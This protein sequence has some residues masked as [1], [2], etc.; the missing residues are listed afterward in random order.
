V[1]LGE[2][3]VGSSQD[4]RTVVKHAFNRFTL[5]KFLF[6]FLFKFCQS[7]LVTPPPRAEELAAVHD[8]RPVE[9]GS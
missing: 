9:A 3:R 2:S 7:T 5:S 4:R 1:T 6:K 8:P